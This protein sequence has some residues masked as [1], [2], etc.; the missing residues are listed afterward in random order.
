[1]DRE[2][3]RILIDIEKWFKGYVKEF[4][5]EDASFNEAMKLKIAHSIRVEKEIEAIGRSSGLGNGDLDL[6]K[7]C[8][9]LHDIGRFEQYRRFATFLDTHSVNHAEL[10]IEV[11][12]KADVLQDLSPEDRETVTAAI[13]F[14]NRASI[15]P[16]NPEKHLLHARMLRDADKI[17]IWKIVTDHYLHPDPLRSGAIELSLPDTPEISPEIEQAILSGEIAKVKS[18][19]SLNDFKLIQAA[20]VFDLNFRHTF[21]RVRDRGYLE[22]I[23]STLPKT[24]RIDVLF[25]AI[26]AYVSMRLAGR[27]PD[28]PDANAE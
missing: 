14:H 28:H 21:E 27:G 1:M 17:D 15:P 22:I 13:S 16:N 9:L 10:G 23:R 5:S 3:N 2:I 7:I 8:G 20:W 26:F 25:E 4:H 19:H 18:M 11:V 6:A 12:Q 24:R